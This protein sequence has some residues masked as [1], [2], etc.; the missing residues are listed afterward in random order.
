MNLRQEKAASRKGVD[1]RRRTA[2][3]PQQAA[4]RGGSSPGRA[5]C[6]HFGAF[7]LGMVCYT[8]G[9]YG[10]AV[11]LVHNFLKDKYSVP[12]SGG[13]DCCA[14][15]GKEDEDENFSD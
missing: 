1:A 3:R 7:F 12:C 9:D 6:L 2:L 11:F 14:D 5:V 15:E 4:A 13:F 8:K 10:Q